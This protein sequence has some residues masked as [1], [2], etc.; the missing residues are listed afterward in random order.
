MS[1]AGIDAVSFVLRTNVVVRL[2]PFH[3][4]TDELMKFDPFT[5]S[6]NAAP[7]AV[8]LVG[9][10]ELTV[11]TGFCAAAGVTD[12]RTPARMKTRNCPRLARATFLTRDERSDLH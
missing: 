1:L 11:G 5:V 12:A 9:E 7:P 3:R 10:M 2:L 6:V 8:A 4:T